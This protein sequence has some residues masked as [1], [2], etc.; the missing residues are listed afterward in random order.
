MNH[1]EL[2]KKLGSVEAWNAWRIEHPHERPNFQGESLYGLFDTRFPEPGAVKGARAQLSGI[3]LADANLRNAFLE[4]ADLHRANLINADLENAILTDANLEGAQLEGALLRDA[5]MR[6]TGLRGASLRKANLMYT[7]FNGADLSAA[8]LTDSNIYGVSAWNVH[9]D[10]HTQQSSL[11]IENYGE[12]S[13]RVPSLEL[14]QFFYMLRDHN[15]LRDVIAS[16]VERG[17]L[18]LGRFSEERK[19]I[20]EAVADALL[21]R[22]YLP[23]IFDFK[24]IPGKDVSETIVTLA[25]LSRFVIAD[26]TQPRS[27]PQEA[28]AIIPHQKVPFIPIQQQGEPRWSMFE[29]FMTYPWV[30]K[31]VRTYRTKDDV[32][33]GLDELINEAEVLFSKLSNQKQHGSAQSRPM[34]ASD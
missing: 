25:S 32:M 4:F 5:N 27:I 26:I 10:E 9:L 13:I 2:L 14:A 34:R 21:K 11:R 3:N 24:E 23:M 20:I 19:V 29:T 28:Q 1:L 31:T 6:R 12:P 30:I 8:D 22:D 18:L 16:V 17:V 15:R 7:Q 33:G